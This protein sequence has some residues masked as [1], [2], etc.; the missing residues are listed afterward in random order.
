VSRRNAGAEQSQKAAKIVVEGKAK[1]PAHFEL[2]FADG[3][4]RILCE[5]T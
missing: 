3:A 2:A 5:L 4:K 1:I